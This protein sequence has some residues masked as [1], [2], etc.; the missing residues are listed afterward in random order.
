MQ[1]SLFDDEV[2][3][4]EVNDTPDTLEISGS[5]VTAEN[6]IF[7]SFPDAYKPTARERK[8]LLIAFAH[9]N[10]VVY[11]QGYDLIK[12]PGS[13][14]EQIKKILSEHSKIMSHIEEIFLI[15]VKSAARARKRRSSNSKLDDFSGHFFGLTTAELLVAQNNEEKFR[16]M[17]V[18]LESK[19]ILTLTLQEFFNRIR[20]IYPQWSI[21]FI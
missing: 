1:Q 18:N 20:K 2:S 5:K 16:F 8:R 17:F 9:K 7:A 4:E 14:R 11:G 19:S 3:L 21:S 12:I 15:E 6:I 10:K 13:T